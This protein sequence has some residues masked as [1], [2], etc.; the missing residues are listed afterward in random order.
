MLD[1]RTKYAKRYI[2]VVKTNDLAE[3]IFEDWS[4]FK[5]VEAMNEVYTKVGEYI[6]EM[7]SEAAK[8][9]IKKLKSKLKVILPRTLRGFVSTG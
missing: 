6:N 3:Y 8:E 5:K 4:G 1:G 9:N 7:F 2:I